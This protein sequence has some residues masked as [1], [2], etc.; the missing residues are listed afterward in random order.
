MNRILLLLCAVVVAIFLWGCKSPL[1]RS[2]EQD[3]REQLFASQRAYLQAVEGSPQQELVRSQSD[4]ELKLSPERRDELDQLSGVGAYEARPL[5]LSSDLMGQTQTQTV[6]MT[7]E[8][9][10]QMAARNNLQVEIA[11]IQPGVEQTR[12]TQAE[13]VFD[14]VFFT[15][16]RH[17]KTD[18]PRPPLAGATAS[19]FGSAQSDDTGFTT[20]FR[21]A[22]STGGQATIATDIGRK[23]DDPSFFADPSYYQSAIVLGIEQPLL[24]NF[25]SDVNRFQ[26]ELARNARQASVAEFKQ[27]LIELATNVERAYWELLLARQRLLIQTRLLERGVRDRGTVEK[28]IDFDAEPASVTQASSQVEQRR[29]EVIKARQEVRR[30]SD[31]LKRLI[32]SPDLPVAGETLVVPLDKPVDEPMVFSL[33]DAISTALRQRPE[34]HRLLF[35]IDDASIRQRVADNLRLPLLNLN[36]QARINGIGNNVGDA[37]SDVSDDDFIDYLIGLNFELPIG[38]REREALYRQRQLERRQSVVAYQDQAQQVVLEVKTAMREMIAGYELI[39]A[40]RSSRRAA[41]ENV[42]NLQAKEDAGAALT[43]DFIDL[44]LRRQEALAEAEF[45]EASAMA[46][47]NVAIANFYAAMGTL[48]E[49]NGVQFVDPLHEKN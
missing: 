13:A 35:Q 40:E 27:N 18:T 30:R 34:L 42:R 19:P 1:E 45:R 31:E 32:N 41:A 25:G 33:V 26:I 37:Y 39:S 9:A 5:E 20:G 48:L 43:P 10:I 28:R 47:Y 14:A 12:V 21:K 15:D 49:R 23:Y 17:N 2:L 22:L 8:R 29:A 44:K 38:N 3:L 24:R 4:T 16:F 36:A 6:S 7:L 46:G 11:R